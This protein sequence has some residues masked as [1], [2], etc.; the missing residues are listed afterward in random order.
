MVVAMQECQVKPLSWVPFITQGTAQAG[1]GVAIVVR[2]V[3]I[4]AGIRIGGIK[5]I[6][7]GIAGR[8]TVVPVVLCARKTKTGL[9]SA[10]RAN[11]KIAKGAERAVLPVGFGDNVNDT[12]HGAGTIQAAGRA[13][14]NFNAL[15]RGWVYGRPVGAATVGV[16][17]THAID[18]NQG[19]CRAG[20]TH[21]YP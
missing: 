16:V 2:V 6:T 10:V 5:A 17:N 14:D 7:G 12:P 9:E 3:N 1:L 11:T 13:A 18:Q 19:L 8:Q 20:P 4:G 15:N 21:K